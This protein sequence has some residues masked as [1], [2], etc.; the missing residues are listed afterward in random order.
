M[1]CPTTASSSATPS[2]ARMQLPSLRLLF[3][4][5]RI[6]LASGFLHKKLSQ[7]LWS[8]YFFYFFLQCIPTSHK[9]ER[10]VWAGAGTGL[11]L[12]GCRVIAFCAAVEFKWIQYC[13]FTLK[14]AQ[15]QIFHL[16]FLNGEIRITYPTGTKHWFCFCA[17]PHAA[18]SS[19]KG[20]VSGDTGEV[21]YPPAFGQP[22]CRSKDPTSP[23]LLL[24]LCCSLPVPSP[25][26]LSTPPPPLAFC[27]F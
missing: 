19:G 13:I 20:G 6:L 7:F 15:K 4:P 8:F 16:H 21:K 9:R 3:M 14:C 25:P 22:A 10:G 17:V 12:V 2:S 24:L 27:L 23:C 11:V 26:P 5:Q 1:S 18:C